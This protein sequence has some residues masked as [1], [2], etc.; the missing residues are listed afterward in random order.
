M[1]PAQHWPD[2][3]RELVDAIAGEGVSV[4]VAPHVG[5]WRVFTPGASADYDPALGQ[6]WHKDGN[7][8]PSTG[9]AALAHLLH[10][11]RSSTRAH[12]LSARIV[13]A[14]PSA[15]VIE[16][17]DGI[18]VRVGSKSVRWK[19]ERNGWSL[20]SLRLFCS[21]DRV[22]DH[23]KQM[24]ADAAQPVRSLEP[25]PSP[26]AQELIDLLR[27]NEFEPEYL[28]DG[29][30]EYL[31]CNGEEL[32][33]EDGWNHW[34]Y[35]DA[36]WNEPGPRM[37][38]RLSVKRTAGVTGNVLDTDALKR[39]IEAES[40]K[41]QAHATKGAT[42]MSTIDQA[43]VDASEAAMRTAARQLT[44]LAREPLV[45]LLTRHLAPGDDAFRARLAAFLETELGTALL[46][47]MLSATLSA[48]PQAPSLALPLAREL[49]VGAMAD[50]GGVLA[51][52]LLG[53]LLQVMRLYLQ[54]PAGTPAAPA[55]EEPKHTATEWTT[56]E[57]KEG[58]R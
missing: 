51:D 10:E 58:A 39:A 7:G 57:Q 1:S 37:L 8:R 49:R 27:A 42:T 46:A 31:G 30:R 23:A 54:D 45:G 4:H 43:K 34:R 9:T 36:N 6:W 26:R 17:T 52:V 33:T 12:A 22:I 41:Q 29:E 44:K 24:A 2:D 55:L 20:P 48:L 50:A 56:A 21:D 3:V 32:Y 47:S 35:R 13:A 38:Y 14:V 28:R 5:G 15:S 40:A 18:E 19:R 25:Q 11:A 53:P 16:T